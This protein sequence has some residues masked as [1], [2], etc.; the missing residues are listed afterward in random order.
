MSQW[1][2]D[3]PTAHGPRPGSGVLRHRPED[4]CVVEQL[5]PPGPLIGVETF[6]DNP[7]DPV[8]GDGE[9]LLLEIEKTGDNTAWLAAELGRMAGCG[10]RGIGFCGLKDR[11]AVT[12]QWFSVQRPGL[13][14][15]DGAFIR[16]VAE[17]WPVF[18]GGRQTRK[19]RRGEHRGNDF[20]ITLRAVEGDHERINE[21]LARIAQQGCP[22]YFGVQ[23]FGI[24]GNNLVQAVTDAQRPRNRG[25]NR[26]GR[27]RNS[28]LWLSAARSWIF[29]EVLAARVEAG[30][31]QCRLTGEPDPEQVTGPLWGDGGTL[32]TDL[33]GQLER[34]VAES[35]PSLL[36]VFADTRMAPERRALVMH[37][38]QLEWE[39][40]ETGCLVLKFGLGKGQFATSLL[41]EVLELQVRSKL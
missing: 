19:L 10:E 30:N 6:L 13:A 37:P 33:Q 3:W 14:A 40:D 36:A 31:W 38:E 16:A 9:H 1:R 25:R 22:G 8:P 26:K 7:A 41:S 34:T 15:E 21:R 23:R 17:R 12:R 2:L 5:E 39:W 32:A 20:R 28:G 11:H 24:D 27:S 4:F 29:N 35:E 18:R